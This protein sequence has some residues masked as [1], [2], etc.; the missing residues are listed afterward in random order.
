[1]D[2]VKFLDWQEYWEINKYGRAEPFLPEGMEKDIMTKKLNL[3]CGSL[4]F[5][6]EN[7]W[8]N[9]DRN[10]GPGIVQ[11]DIYD[12]PWPFPDNTFE[13]IFMSNILEHICHVHWFPLMNELFR[14]SKKGAIWEIQGPDPDNYVQTLQAPSHTGLVGPW[15]FFEYVMP[16]G[17]GDLNQS[18]SA[19]KFQ[20]VPLDCQYSKERPL[21]WKR[22]YAFYL[23]HIND[24]HFRKY[25]GRGLG[26]ILSRILGN[27][28]N[29][30]LVYRVIK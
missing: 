11:H 12:I 1:M 20:L 10:E 27:P 26:E 4:V 9:L 30:R 25:L 15:T 13:Y 7:G 17:H 8:T 5:D 22:F 29:L 21:K 19:R 6:P 14:V 3:G 24:Y 18:R 28:W 23:G 16:K 2:D